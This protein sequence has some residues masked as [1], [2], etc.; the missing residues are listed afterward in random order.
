MVKKVSI[1]LSPESL[2]E[3]DYIRDR[4]HLHPKIKLSNLIQQV[5]FE[6]YLYLQRSRH[7]SIDCDGD[8]SICPDDQICDH[9]KS[10]DR[11][12]I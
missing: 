11:Y 10:I 12:I 5:I 6:Q 9:S 7:G 4:L 1:S 8:C 2:G 3:L